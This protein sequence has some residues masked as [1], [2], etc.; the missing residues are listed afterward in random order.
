MTTRLALSYVLN[1]ARH[2]TLHNIM[3]QRNSQSVA[4]DYAVESKVNDRVAQMQLYL[5]WQ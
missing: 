1:T 5:T 2:C 3:R 4:V